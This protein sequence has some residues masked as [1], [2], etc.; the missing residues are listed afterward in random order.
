MNNNNL[1]VFVLL[2]VSSLL[3]TSGFADNITK[4]HQQELIDWQQKMSLTLKSKLED[5]LEQIII[6]A[7]YSKI[8]QNQTRNLL[9]SADN[10]Y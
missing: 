7:E 4:K 10:R 1:K 9:T 6:S 8:L 5:K 3:S 2:T